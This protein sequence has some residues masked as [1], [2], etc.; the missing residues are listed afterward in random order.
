[1]SLD[2]NQAIAEDQAKEQESQVRERETDR[3]RIETDKRQTHG[4]TK[5]EEVKER[6]SRNWVNPEELSGIMRIVQPGVYIL[7]SQKNSPP[8]F[9][10]SSLFIWIFCGHLSFIKVS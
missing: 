5:D 9:S 6:R 1:M 8:P 4:K 3:Q 2:I 7:A 10:N